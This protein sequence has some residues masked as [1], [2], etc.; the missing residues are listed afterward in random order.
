MLTISIEYPTRHVANIILARPE[1]HNA[2]DER[3]IAELIQALDNCAKDENIRVLL[4]SAQGKNFSAGADLRWMQKM[5][6]YTEEE[7]FSDAKQLATLLQ[8][9]KYFPKPTIAIINGATFGGGIGLIACCDIAIAARSATFCFSE[10]KLGLIPAVI[11]PYISQTV[12]ARQMQRYFT[13]AETFSAEKALAMG[14]LH[15]ITDTDKLYDFALVLTKKI[16]NNSP[17]ALEKVKQLITLTETATDQAI[18]QQETCK[19]IAEIR[20][21]KEGQEGLQAFLE[22]RRPNWI[23]S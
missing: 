11:A 14:L 5:K 7:N 13:T 6:Q 8:R 9:L 23:S 3:M 10:V 1:K 17:A 4:L 21:S 2:F 16:L 19:M 18:L 15:E 20:V 12:P 22:K